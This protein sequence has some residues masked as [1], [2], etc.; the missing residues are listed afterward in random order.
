MSAKSGEVQEPSRCYRD[1]LE[2]R[3]SYSGTRGSFGIVPTSDGAG[4]VIE[5]GKGVERFKIG[6]RVVAA[7]MTPWLDG[8]LTKERQPSALGGGQVNEMLAEEVV[9]PAS[10]VLP[11]PSHLRAKD[12]H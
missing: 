11:V 6:D 9:L 5:V 4:E 1:L 3:G 10:A 12:S 7:F 2:A 8:D